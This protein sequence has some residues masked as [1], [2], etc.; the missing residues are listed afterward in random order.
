MQADRTFFLALGAVF[1]LLA[2]VTDSAQST[3]SLTL[4]ARLRA[5]GDQPKDK[6]VEKTIQWDP[7]KTAIIICDMWDKH[8]CKGATE[9]VAEMAPRMNEVL[10]EARKH[11]VLII[12]APSSTMKF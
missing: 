11:G 5:E 2:C 3:Q 6:A 7:K 1:V 9:R 4:H 10:T 8:W 12:H